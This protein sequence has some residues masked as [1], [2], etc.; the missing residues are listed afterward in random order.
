MT[1]PGMAFRYLWARRGVT[2]LTVISLALGTALPCAILLLREQSENALLREGSGVD[3]VVGGKGSPLQLVLSAVHHVDLPTGNIPLALYHSLREDERVRAAVPLSLGDNFAGYRI[4]GTTA[5]FFAWRP[6][7]LEDG[8]SWLTLRAGRAF[9]EPFEVV[10]GADVARAH[11]FALGDSFVGSH[12]LRPAPGTEH[13]DFPYVVTGILEPS[14]GVV[15]RLIL[16]PLDS[17]WLVHEADE[18]MHRNLFGARRER[19]ER[20][21]EVTAVW[22]RLRSAGMRMWMRDE[23][24]RNTDAMAAVPVD[25]LH[26]LYQRVLKPVQQGLLWMAAAVALVSGLAILATLLQATERRRRDWAVLRT[27]GAHPREIFTLVWL[28]S[29][30]ISTLGVLLGILLAHGGLSAA[31]H[32]RSPEFLTGFTPFHL[33]EHQNAVLLGIWVGGAFFGVIPALFGY[34]RS[35]VEDLSRD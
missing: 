30:W 32:F 13:D 12:G 25:E 19:P 27:L 10:L 21:P 24:N 35:P 11:G 2:L 29:L 14:G 28:E 17:V 5:D 7:N 18:D 22:L 8:A 31:F 3:M 26:R 23:I 16:T 34:R 20:E 15:D 9:E 1:L 6:R 33:A 4:V